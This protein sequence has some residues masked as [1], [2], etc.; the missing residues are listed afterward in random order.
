MAQ[1]SSNQ[2][3]KA[4]TYS[5]DTLALRYVSGIGLIALGVVLFLAVGLR[6]QG[7]VF[8]QLR[9]LSFGLCGALA[10]ALPIWPVWGGVLV[11]WSAQKKAPFRPW[12]APPG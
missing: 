4:P 3:R 1:K 6:M 10:V 11:C 12:A 5:A 7:N 9:S 8:D 2:R